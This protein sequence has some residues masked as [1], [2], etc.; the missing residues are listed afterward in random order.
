MSKYL[1]KVTEEYRCDTDS[2]AKELIEQAKSNGMYELKTY[3]NDYKE[4]KS[5]GEIIDCYFITKLVKVFNDPKE[6]IE[7]FDVEYVQK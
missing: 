1:T 5:K 3:S 6:P 4:R 7:Q 2:E